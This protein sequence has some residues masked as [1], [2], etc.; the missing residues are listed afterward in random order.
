MGRGG[1]DMRKHPGASVPDLV[2]PGGV[3]GGLSWMRQKERS[4]EFEATGQERNVAF[5]PLHR[6]SSGYYSVYWR[7]KPV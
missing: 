3:S 7:V 2:E 6:L 4:L 1:A 5:V